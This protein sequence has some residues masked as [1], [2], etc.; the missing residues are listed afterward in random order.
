MPR[1]TGQVVFAAPILGRFAVRFEEGFAVIE[2][3][4]AEPIEV[5]DLIEGDL[6]PLGGQDFFNRSK[7]CT[8]DAK[9]LAMAQ[10]ETSARRMLA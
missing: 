2:L 3:L 10:D 7:A 9:L 4:E 6:D 5:G 1:M 8:L